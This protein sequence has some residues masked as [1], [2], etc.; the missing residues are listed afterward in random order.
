[1]CDY[2]LRINT[3]MHRL[4][5]GDLTGV[6]EEDLRSGGSTSGRSQIKEHQTLFKYP[7]VA[8]CVPLSLFRWQVYEVLT[9][10]KSGWRAVLENA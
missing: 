2:A 9:H 5:L 6:G 8:L 4:V 3:H 1:M 10:S 7:S